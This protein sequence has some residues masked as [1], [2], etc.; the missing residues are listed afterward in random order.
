LTVAI[1]AHHLKLALATF[2]AIVLVAIHA[3]RAWQR[4]ALRVIGSWI[5]ASGILAL[6]LR[7]AR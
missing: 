1:L 2:A 4:I 3:E 5:A 7:L 6:A